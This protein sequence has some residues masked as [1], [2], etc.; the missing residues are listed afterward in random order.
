MLLRVHVRPAGGL[1]G[2]RPL[3]S[4]IEAAKAERSRPSL[5]M[6]RTIIGWPAP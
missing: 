4:A 2:D 6:L 3:L 1:R 5:I